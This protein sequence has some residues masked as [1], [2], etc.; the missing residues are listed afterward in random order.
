M[1]LETMQRILPKLGRKVVIDSSARSVLPL[2][3]LDQP[4]ASPSA[5]GQTTKGG[6]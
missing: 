2:L 5:T 4:A 6:N 1:Y 3:Q